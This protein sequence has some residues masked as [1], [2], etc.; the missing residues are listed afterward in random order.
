MSKKNTPLPFELTEEL[1]DNTG[2][3]SERKKREIP[4][5]KYYKKGTVTKK[6]VADFY[7]DINELYCE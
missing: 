7:N 5:R 1:G 4:L 6:K 3:T 2:I